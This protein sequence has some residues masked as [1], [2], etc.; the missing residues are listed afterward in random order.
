MLSSLE[1]KVPISGPSGTQQQRI[2][3][4]C[5]KW[6]GNTG[7]VRGSKP[8]NKHKITF[9]RL[10]QWRQR[11]RELERKRKD[12][13]AILKYSMWENIDTT[14]ESSFEGFCRFSRI[15]QGWEFLQREELDQDN[16]SG[17]KVG[18]DWEGH[19]TLDNWTRDGFRAK[20]ISKQLYFR[21][22]MNVVDF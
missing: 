9:P 10:L 19:G 22:N 20:V 8:A 1:T 16:G 3:Y 13:W 21:F 4:F 5:G 6:F 2:W 7:R 18:G 11:Q 14:L 17:Q 12:L 15:F